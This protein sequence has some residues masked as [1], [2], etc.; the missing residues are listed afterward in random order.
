MAG[1]I[2]ATLM[3][4]VLNRRI[5]VPNSRSNEEIGASIDTGQADIEAEG[6]QLHT[7]VLSTTGYMGVKIDRNK[8]RADYHAKFLGSFDTAVEAAVAYAKAVGGSAENRANGLAPLADTEAEG[9]KLHTSPNSNSGYL[10]VRKKSCNKFCVKYKGKHLGSFA[11]AV[12]AAVAY[13]RAVRQGPHGTAA[14]HVSQKRVR[15]P[16]YKARVR[17]MIQAMVPT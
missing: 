5:R 15:L 17:L 8:F 6:L 13:A 9:L 1:A 14:A 4:A 12:E 3:F 7:S 10:G 11:S 16:G 2:L